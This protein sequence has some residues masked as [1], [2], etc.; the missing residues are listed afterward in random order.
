MPDEPE[1]SGLPLPASLV[2]AHVPGFAIHD[3]NGLSLDLGANFDPRVDPM[4]FIQHDDVG[5]LLKWGEQHAE[6]LLRDES[7]PLEERQFFLFRGLTMEAERKT[8]Q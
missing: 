4:V 1:F 7:I 8:T 5:A 2:L 6:A 3:Q